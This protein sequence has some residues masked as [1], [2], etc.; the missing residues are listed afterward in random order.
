MRR[1]SCRIERLQTA[2]RNFQKGS[3]SAVEVKVLKQIGIKT[4]RHSTTASRHPRPM[5]PKSWT[6]GRKQAA[7]AVIWEHTRRDF[8]PQGL[9]KATMVEAIPNQVCW[10]IA[11]LPIGKVP[12]ATTTS[13]I[14][15]ARS[16]VP[17][18][19]ADEHVHNGIIMH[20]IH[21]REFPHLRR[22]CNIPDTLQ[23]MVLVCPHHEKN[24]EGG[25]QQPLEGIKKRG[26]HYQRPRAWRS[27]EVWWPGH[28]PQHQPMPFWTERHPLRVKNGL[29]SSKR[30][31]RL[32]NSGW[33]P[34]PV[35]ITSA[36]L[37][38]SLFN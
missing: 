3:V 29:F 36:A 20:H 34:G 9:Q 24:A 1:D 26:R 12:V 35:G 15:E 2:C 5:D 30:L 25:A 28:G 11:T 22:F 19:T 14:K 33:L 21:P 18:Q 38:T 27:S 16:H 7:H 23:H 4:N 32:L 10:H 17:L 6:R 31:F 8:L 37:N 13:K